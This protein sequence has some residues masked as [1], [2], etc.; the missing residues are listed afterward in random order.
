MKKQRTKA[1]I[2]IIDEKGERAGRISPSI[3]Y[4]DYGFLDKG[5]LADGRVVI[6]EGDRWVYKIS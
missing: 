4:L 5:V 2:F 1:P 6:R 3:I